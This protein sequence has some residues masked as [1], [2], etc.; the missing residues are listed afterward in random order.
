MTTTPRHWL[1]L[2]AA[3]GAFA[4]LA[5]LAGCGSEFPLPT[6][7]RNRSIPPDGS[8]QRLATWTSLPGV[9]DLALVPRGQLDQLYFV[10][11]YGGAGT[12]PRGEVW[13]YLL[14]RP[15]RISQRPFN[16]LFN[17]IGIASGNNRLWVL[18]LGDS[19]LARQNPVTGQCNDTTGGWR[20]AISHL[21]LYWWV[22]GYLLIAGDP[23][24]TFTDTSLATV[25]GI[26]SDELN[27][28]YVAGS[29]IRFIPDQEDPRL[30]VKLLE[31]GV[32]KYSPGLR[33]DGKTDLTVLPAGTWHRDTTF[34][35]TQ[36]TGS[37]SA[38]DPRGIFWGNA[39]GAHR[40]YVSDFGNNQIKKTFDQGVSPGEI[41][42]DANDSGTA[43]EGPVDVT[44]DPLGYI[45]SVDSGSKRIL[46]FDAFGTYQQIVNTEGD[47][48]VRPVA[49]AADDS[50]CY[51]A[52]PGGARVIRYKRRQ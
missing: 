13:E 28:V 17:P 29:R 22:R 43:L 32:F 48:L 52:D 36:G 34:Q 20:N 27:N 47:A 9:V 50:L 38:I 40:I 4:L 12:T 11:N 33:P 23:V 15:E 44:A 46:R 26:A 2:A 51:V 21:E 1:R 14:V 6:E 31:Y 30:R 3:L 7:N 25:T 37:G 5:S 39:S 10:F 35:V 8:Y 19:C 42:F 41:A 18:D 16:G 24:V 49:V 45:Y